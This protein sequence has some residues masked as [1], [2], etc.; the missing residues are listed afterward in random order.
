MCVIPLS[1]HQEDNLT[2][3]QQA[4]TTITR[5][6]RMS[7]VP[8]DVSLVE[9]DEGYDILDGRQQDDPIAFL[10]ESI[11]SPEAMCTRTVRRTVDLSHDVHSPTFGG[12]D[13]VCDVS[14]KEIN[15]G[16]AGR[17]TTYTTNNKIG[18]C[19]VCNASVVW[20]SCVHKRDTYIL[21]GREKGS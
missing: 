20:R 2:T 5:S 19:I 3:S 9:V 18:F 15:N 14:P 4:I 17:V 16:N 8:S 11:I 7:R 10:A 1:E 6:G 13:G 21:S 12:I